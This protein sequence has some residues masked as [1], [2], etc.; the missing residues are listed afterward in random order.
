MIKFFKAIPVMF[1]VSE[2]QDSDVV[3]NV[4]F[5]IL[6]GKIPQLLSSLF[7]FYDS[8]TQ[9]KTVVQSISGG[10][11]LKVAVVIDPGFEV[12]KVHYEN[13]DKIFTYYG[14]HEDISRL[15]K[16]LASDK[17][18]AM[19]DE[20]YMSRNKNSNDLS[21]YE[22]TD[23]SSTGTGGNYEDENTPSTSNTPCKTQKMDPSGDSGYNPGTSLNASRSLLD[24]IIEAV[25]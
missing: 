9:L 3:E 11:K 22:Y 7:V 19:A 6:Y 13:M 5:G 17:V 23:E 25:L 1:K 12:G 20:S 14:N 18:H 4:K 16:L 8:L 10:K 2:V 15:E 24:E 21:I